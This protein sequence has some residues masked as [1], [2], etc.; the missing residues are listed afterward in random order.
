MEIND[1]CKYLSFSTEKLVKVGMYFTKYINS[2]VS[3]TGHFS[4]EL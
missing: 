3:N 2:G 1:K 4:A